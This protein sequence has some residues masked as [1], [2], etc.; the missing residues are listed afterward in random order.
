MDLQ[1]LVLAALLPLK[2]GGDEAS[3]RT[4]VDAICAAAMDAPLWPVPTEVAPGSPEVAATAL[5]LSAIALHES[6]FDPRVGDCRVRGGGA[7][8]YFQLLGHFAKAG[9]EEEEICSSPELAARL[10]LRVIRSQ[11]DHCKHCS[12]ARWFHGYASGNPGVPSRASRSTVELWRTMAESV[13]LRV[14]PLATTHP[15]FLR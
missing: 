8:T 6:H 10:A 3:R 9:H 15:H 11:R 4:A 7:I 12:P 2:P 5:L 1:A 14:Y 13:R